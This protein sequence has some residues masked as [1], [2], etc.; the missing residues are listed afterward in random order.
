MANFSSLGR[1]GA[2]GL[3]LPAGTVR[4]GM[5][6]AGMVPAL[7]APSGAGATAT[8]PAHTVSAATLPQIASRILKTAVPA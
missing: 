5:V 6:P 1:K 8:V 3:V 4:A 7:L 2:D